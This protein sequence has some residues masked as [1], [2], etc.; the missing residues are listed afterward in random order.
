MIYKLNEYVYL[1]KNK[2]TFKEELFLNNN[3]KLVYCFVV[4]KNGVVEC[5]LQSLY[6][7]FTKN[8]KDKAIEEYLNNKIKALEYGYSQLNNNAKALIKLVSCKIG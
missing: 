5:L 7:G 4:V 2:Y 8:E 3:N 1:K 6:N